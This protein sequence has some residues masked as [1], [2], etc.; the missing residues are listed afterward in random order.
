MIFGMVACKP[1]NTDQTTESTTTTEKQPSTEQSDPTKVF[2]E[3]KI[4]FSFAAISD[5]HIGRNANELERN[6]FKNALLQLKEYAAKN[7]TDVLAPP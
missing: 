1:N 3:S 4:V 7:D 5:I 6:K 2:D